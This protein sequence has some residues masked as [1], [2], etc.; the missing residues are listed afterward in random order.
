MSVDSL[1]DLGTEGRWLEPSVQPIFFLRIDDSQC[2]I[3]YFSITNIHCFDD[4][5]VG[6]QPV[7]WKEYCWEYWLKEI[8]KRM[9]M[10]TGRSKITEIT[11]KTALNTI[12]SINQSTFSFHYKLYLCIFTDGATCPNNW[13]A[14][15]DSCY[16]FSREVESWPGSLVSFSI[17]AY[18]F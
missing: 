18:T 6:K 3:I 5:N 2:D 11:S 16:F 12:K 14:H 1:D 13:S 7:A 15:D 8:Q 9:H 4:G 10:C 17:K